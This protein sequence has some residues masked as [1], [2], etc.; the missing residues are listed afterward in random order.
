M[1]L[2]FGQPCSALCVPPFGAIVSASAIGRL[3]RVAQDTPARDWPLTALWACLGSKLSTYYLNLFDDPFDQGVP[4]WRSSPFGS[5]E[6]LD[7]GSDTAKACRE[8][9]EKGGSVVLRHTHATRNGCPTLS[10]CLQCAGCP[11]GLSEEHSDDAKRDERHSAEHQEPFDHNAVRER[12]R[13]GLAGYCARPST[14]T[15]T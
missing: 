14:V 11:I 2:Q 4:N 5:G 12:K 1:W 3:Q 13:H 9:V 10:A 8:A 7:H 15:H 6:I